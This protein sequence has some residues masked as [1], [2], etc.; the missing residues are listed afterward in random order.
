M[1]FK[2]SSI[3]PTE[4]IIHIS[5]L[6]PDTSYMLL[7]SSN[8]LD[9]MT[10]SNKLD[11]M[12]PLATT[13]S[14]T[15]VSNSQ[16]ANNLSNVQDANNLSNS[17]GTNTNLRNLPI[18]NLRFLPIFTDGNLWAVIHYDSENPLVDEVYEYRQKH[19][20]TWTS[21]WLHH[22]TNPQNIYLEKLYFNTVYE[23]RISSRDPY[24]KIIVASD[25]I[26]LPP[27]TNSSDSRT[28]LQKTDVVN[29][30]THSAVIRAFYDLLDATTVVMVRVR[31]KG[32]QNWPSIIRGE[33]PRGAGD[34]PIY[35]A[36]HFAA[37]FNGEPS[38]T[39]EYQIVSVYGGIT[40][41]SP[42]YEFTMK[43]SPYETKPTALTENLVAS[44]AAGLTENLI[45]TNHRLQ[46]S[47]TGASV[48]FSGIFSEKPYIDYR[49]V[50]ST[51]WKSLAASVYGA[52]YFVD[53]KNLRYGVYE[54]RIRVG[55]SVTKTM[56]FNYP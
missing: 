5:E 48:A 47:G 34:V 42:V 49:Q 45:V 19:S 56:K 4:A 22:D 32:S 40:K 14:A 10:P 21:G 43:V 20:D 29:I 41:Y 30:Q 26:T 9:F 46:F 39:Y 31:V 27:I 55:G 33:I 7:C 17:Q 35:L 44:S 6:T 25:I 28:N 38:T 53:F 15:T 2:I 11:F 23:L 51:V 54:Y 8:K 36:G 12:T 1:N 37:T 50:G 13:N 52:T 16:D 18:V 3:S 24:K